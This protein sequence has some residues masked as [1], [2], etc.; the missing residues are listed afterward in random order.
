[1]CELRE[2][3]YEELDNI[4]DFLDENPNISIEFSFNYEYSMSESYYI[5]S[6]RIEEILNYL[7]YNG[8]SEQ[9]ISGKNYFGSN[10]YTITKDDVKNY[11][12]LKEGDVRNNFV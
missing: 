1:M 2:E 8:I 10:P 4:S 12:F 7:K 5:H 11:P 3:S 9:R 6:C